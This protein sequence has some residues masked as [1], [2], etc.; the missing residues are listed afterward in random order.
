[1]TKPQHINN[2]QNDRLKW[3]YNRYG[4]K[5][6][7]Y[8]IRVY[9]VNEDVAW[10]I[11]YKALYSVTL[12]FDKYNFENDHKLNGFVFRAFINLLKNHFRDHK[13]Y[14]EEIS[15]DHYENKLIVTEPEEKEPGLRMKILELELEKLEEWERMLLLLRSQE[16]SYRD[17]AKYIDKPEAQLKVYYQRLKKK[18]SDRMQNDFAPNEK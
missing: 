12:N 1:L 7:G 9:K 15:L 18:I 3:L 14:P 16:M 6:C 11:C 10:D 17:I 5:L 8:A 13:K 4:K 2:E